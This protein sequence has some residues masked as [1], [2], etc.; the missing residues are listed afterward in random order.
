MWEV[1]EAL[2]ENTRYEQLAD[3][4]WRA[5]YNGFVKLTAEGGT[6]AA[7]EEQLSRAMDTLLASIIRGGKEREKK[8]TAALMSSLVLSDAITVVRKK[9]R[10]VARFNLERSAV[11][12]RTA[13]DPTAR[14]RRQTRKKAG[15]QP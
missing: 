2:S 3:G 15:G 9:A 8:D 7:S 1:N 11:S 4:R 12:S 5:E 10:Q 14:Q 6:P 13:H